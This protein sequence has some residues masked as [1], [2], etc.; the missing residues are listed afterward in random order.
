[1]SNTVPANKGTLHFYLC[2]Q[3]GE[4]LDDDRSHLRAGRQ[5]KMGWNA[6]QPIDAGHR[7][8]SRSSKTRRKLLAS[9][10]IKR[11][12]LKMKRPADQAF[13]IYFTSIS[14]GRRRHRVPPWAAW[15]APSSSACWLVRRRCPGRRGRRLQSTRIQACPRCLL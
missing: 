8:P 6:D 9:P 5:P 1:M 11:K 10:S 13:V 15:R 2:T 12:T 14:C 7:L 4:R 3:S